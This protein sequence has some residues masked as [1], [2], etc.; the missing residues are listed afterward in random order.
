MVK[1]Q[2]HDGK[3]KDEILDFVQ[4]SKIGIIKRYSK[5]GVEEDED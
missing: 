3:I 5:N 2:V 4:G 1:G